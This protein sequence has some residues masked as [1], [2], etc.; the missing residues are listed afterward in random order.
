MHFGIISVCLTLA[1]SV[2]ILS[3]PSSGVK[4]E[5]RRPVE[6]YRPVY[7]PYIFQLLGDKG[8]ESRTKSF[9]SSG[10]T[11]TS[12][13]A[14]IQTNKNKNPSNRHN[15]KLSTIKLR[16]TGK[17]FDSIYNIHYFFVENENYIIMCTF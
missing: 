11:S 9:T 6:R 8:W 3:D 7:V 13:D 10:V 12:S 16:G 4:V 1:L 5:K 14:I 17:F 15:D 2:G